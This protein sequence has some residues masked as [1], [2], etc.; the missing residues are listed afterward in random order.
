MSKAISLVTGAN[1][2]IGLETALGLALRGDTVWMAARNVGKGEAAVADIKQR[3]GNDDVHLLPLDLA[4]LDSVRAAASTFLAAHDRLDVLVNNA[5]LILGE[6]ETT[7]DGF[8]ATFAINHLGHFLLTH[9]LLGA[10]KAAAPSR[11]VNLSSAGHSLSLGLNFDD[12][13]VE[14][15]AYIGMNVYCDSKL[16]NT[17]FTTELARRLDGTGVIA[18]AVHPG[19]VR[20][21]FA[22]DGDV[23]GWF[24]W[25]AKLISPFMLSSAGGAKT[26]LHVA[27]SEDAGKTTGEY[28]AKRRRK[29]PSKQAR[30]PET[31]ARLW[32][33]SEELLGLSG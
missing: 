23:K 16:A 24:Y 22:M 33:V 25:G 9:L 20:S 32:A 26:S 19:L 13:M 7:V 8:E 2:G 15:R 18:H 6:R 1:S 11:I 17:L 31:A 30:D 28:W 12:L 4:S 29:K 3:S 5:G 10:L 27:T 21:G 14:R